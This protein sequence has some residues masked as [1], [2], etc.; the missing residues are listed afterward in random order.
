[1]QA[2][3]L[4]RL[5]VNNTRLTERGAATLK[6]IVPDVVWSAGGTQYR[7]IVGSE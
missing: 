1:M 3:A 7:Y 5:V 4:Q 2:P 6:K